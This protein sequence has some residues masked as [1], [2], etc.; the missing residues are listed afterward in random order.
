M[1]VDE[2]ANVAAIRS[3][4]NEQLPALL[5]TV[6]RL[7]HQQLQASRDEQNLIKAV[8]IALRDIQRD[9]RN[10]RKDLDAVGVRNQTIDYLTERVEFVRRELMYEMRHGAKPVGAAGDSLEVQSRVIDADK[11]AAARATCLKINLGCG[12]VPLEGYMNVDRRELT[13]VDIVSE[14]TGLPLQPGDV[15]EVFSSHLIEHFPQEQLR[16]ELLPYWKSLLK[17]GGRFRAVVPDAEAM[18]QEYTAGRYP[19]DDMRE[20]MYGGQDY[21]GDFH[22]NMFTPEHMR[23]LL[24]EAGFTRI[25]IPAAGRRNGKC[26]EFEITAINGN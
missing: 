3:V 23:R 20:V 8:P 18:I 1:L 5:E 4:V 19:Y 14:V 13:G 25:E 7:N 10:L 11:L 17:P 26:Y 16:R 2:L 9:I 21:D 12:H 15:D 24:E 22:F 6:S